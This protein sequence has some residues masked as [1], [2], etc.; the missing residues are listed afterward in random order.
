MGRFQLH[1]ILFLLAVTSVLLW[2]TAE[3][4]NMQ[5]QK[6]KKE[7]ILKSD[8]L[9]MLQLKTKKDLKYSNNKIDSLHMHLSYKKRRR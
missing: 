3:K 1:T 9:H 2:L 7:L 5:L 6:Q 8:S 4:E